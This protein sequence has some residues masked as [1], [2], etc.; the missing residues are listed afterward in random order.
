MTLFIFLGVKNHKFQQRKTPDISG[1]SY[2]PYTCDWMRIH[3]PG[4]EIRCCFTKFPHKFFTI[5][6][7]VKFGLLFLKKIDIIIY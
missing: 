4:L 2:V 7:N 3:A 1:V 6:K 5:E